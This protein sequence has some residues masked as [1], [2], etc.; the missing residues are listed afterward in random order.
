MDSG[1]VPNYSLGRPPRRTGL[2]GYSMKVT[3]IVAAGFLLFLLL[4]LIGARMLSWS[5]VAVSFVLAALVQIKFSGRT[6]ASMAQ[7]IEQDTRRNHAGEDVYFSGPCSRVTGGVYQL[8]GLLARTEVVSGVDQQ[9][10]PFAVIVEKA[11][12]LVTVVLDCELTGQTAMVQDERN[13]ATASWGRFLASLSLSGDVEHMSMTVA[14][15]P[16]TGDLVAREVAS[17]IDEDAPWLARQVLLEAAEELCVGLPELDS[18][19]AITVRVDEDGFADESYLASLATRIPTWVEMLNWAGVLATPM[20]EDG[21][22]A[23]VHAAFN[24]PAEGDFEQLRVAGQPHKLSWKNAGPGFARVGRDVYFH[25]GVRS[26]SWEMAEAPRSYFEDHLLTTL[27][28]P[29]NRVQRKRVTLVYRPYE[30]GEGASRVEAEHRDALVA[31]NS[32]KKVRSASAEM[33]LEQTDASRQ[34]QARGAQLGKYSMFVSA[35]VTDDDNLD[36]VCHDVEQLG[37]SCSLRLRRMNRQQDAGFQIALG[38][39]QIPWGQE[40]TAALVSE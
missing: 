15:R 24:P 21:L 12:R 7:L 10:S 18:H 3:L 2:G 30:A 26:V 36:R 5:V 33:R 13:Q 4:Q 14:A 16:G 40:S 25:D 39:G 32:S 27:L 37:A 20:D 22:V 29:H 1:M 34:A 28:A 35:T 31:A 9:G 11:R 17:I 8:P 23:R 6:I 19:V 38:V